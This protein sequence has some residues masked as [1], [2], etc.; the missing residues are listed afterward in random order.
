MK[1]R[2][3]VALGG[4]S[5]ILLGG[6]SSNAILPHPTAEFR[7]SRGSHERVIVIP[8]GPF[9]HRTSAPLARTGFGFSCGFASQA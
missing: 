7:D 9:G 8:T 4:I 3:A 6:S 1:L 5:T 2:F